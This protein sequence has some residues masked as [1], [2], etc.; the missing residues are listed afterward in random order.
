MI[1]AAVAT[2]ALPPADRRTGIEE[3]QCPEDENYER[4]RDWERELSRGLRARTFF[5]QFPQSLT[6]EAGLEGAMRSSG[7][8]FNCV[9][10]AGRKRSA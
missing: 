10:A 6:S 8:T 4:Q 7:Q 5:R 1:G 9:T 2:G 3:R